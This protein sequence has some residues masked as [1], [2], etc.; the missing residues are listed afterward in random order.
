MGKKPSK[1]QLYAGLWFL[2]LALILY[3][4]SVNNGYNIDDNYV[5]EEHEQVQKGIKGIPE[6]FT[7]RYHQEREQYFGYR[8]LTI[9]VYAIEYQI[10]GN[11]PS[12]FHLLNVLWYAVL[13]IVLFRLLQILMP[14]HNSWFFLI[15]LSIFAAHP[16]HS[17]VVLSLKNREEIFCFLLSALAWIS[18]VRYYDIRKWWHLISGLV[19]LALAFLA[20]ETAVIFVAIIPLSL[21]YFRMEHQNQTAN[22]PQNYKAGHHQRIGIGVLQLI[23]LTGVLTEP[24]FLTRF[25]AESLVTIL[26]LLLF[27]LVTLFLMRKQQ[28]RITVSDFKHPLIILA[29]LVFITGL[30]FLA[31]EKDM[32]RWL[33]ALS[34]LLAGLHAQF[35]DLSARIKAIKISKPMLIAG[36]IAI[37]SGIVLLTIHLIPEMSLPEKNA[38]V[39][40]WQNPLFADK[41]PGTRIGVAFYSLAW[42]L[43]LLIIPGPLR[44]YYG[45]AMVPAAG[46]SH[47][48][49]IISLLIHTALIWMMFRGMKQRKIWSFAIAFYLIGIVP[50]SNLFFPLT[51]IIAERL[52]FIPSLGFAMLITW[53]IFRI[54]NE[55]PQTKR[56]SKKPQI[57]LLSLLIVLPFSVITIKRNAEWESRKVLY[58]ADINKLDKSAKANNL[59]ANYLIG[60]V[61]AG[62]KAGVPLQRMDKKIHTSIDYYQRAIKVD[63][64]YAN[65]LHNLGYIYL[66]IGREY[67]RA[68]GYFSRCLRIDSTV[69]EAWLNRG[70]ARY[71]QEKYKQAKSDLQRCVQSGLE[72]DMD[73]AFHY[74]GMIAETRGDTT[75]AIAMYDSVL[76]YSPEQPK[77]LEKL[78]NIHAAGE[79]YQKALEYNGRLRKTASPKN[80]QV[81]VD[82]GNIHLMSGDTVQAVQAWEKAFNIFPGNYNIGM[83]LAGYYEDKGMSRKASAIRK[84]AVEFRRRQGNQKANR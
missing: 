30:V 80:D 36:G 83:T 43:K 16:I 69:T 39:Y 9:A 51:G 27:L 8:P 20:K 31:I 55:N 37:V 63:S 59:V 76:T 21:Y 66:I 54:V 72:K 14:G 52:L 24:E 42:Y 57:I 29:I 10:F 4:Q 33:V 64:T 70:V 82:K 28:G 1:I 62:M 74:L 23:F 6:I 18:F 41:S 65:P 5:V 19:L 32:T 73:K 61:Y 67:E 12:V 13:L 77:S 50:F 46:L 3:G 84:K 68:E 79:S 49:V 7:S 22:R 58:Q 60:E 81:W 47:P 40:N 48:V 78:Q 34:L 17:E 44:F 11:N 75:K 2:I 15:L 53:F 25:L 45:Y 26:F 35:P 71:H 56:L 38:P